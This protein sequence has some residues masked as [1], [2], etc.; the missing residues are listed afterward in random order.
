M[1]RRLLCLVL[2]ACACGSVAA[3]APSTRHHTSATKTK[4]AAA[5]PRPAVS[6]SA[7]AD[8]SGAATPPD[9]SARDADRPAGAATAAQRAGGARRLDDV[10]IEGEVSAPQVLF[11][12]ARDQRRFLDFHHRR[13]LRTS[14]QL[15]E[16][17]AFPTS[18]TV[19]RAPG[20][21]RAPAP[22]TATPPHAETTR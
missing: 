6:A 7:S 12:T 14:R 2:L 16:A 11:I 20:E 9:T 21:G 15:G 18:I 17:T 19:A 13:Y 10:H 8:S 3:A 4:R 5:R 1:I 22:A